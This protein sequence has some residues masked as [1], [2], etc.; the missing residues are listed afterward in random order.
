MHIC[1]PNILWS[2]YTNTVMGAAL[3]PHIVS[4]SK[5][6]QPRVH[7]QYFKTDNCPAL[8][9]ICTLVSWPQW[10]MCSSSITRP[11]LDRKVQLWLQP[12]PPTSLPTVPTQECMWNTLI[13]VIAPFLVA[14]ILIRTLV[15]WPQW[16]TSLCSR[17][18]T[19][20]MLASYP[21]LI[22]TAWVRGY[23]YAWQEGAHISGMNCKMSST[24]IL[25]GVALYKILWG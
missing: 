15:N 6:Y 20:C 23:L 10:P 18:I 9:S 5:K 24:V 11:M 14:L 1:K 3:T 21:G 25:N 12:L 16:P 19:C 2:A 13:M 8:I 4:H 22:W 7:V 17:S